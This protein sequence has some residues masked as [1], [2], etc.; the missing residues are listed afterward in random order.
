MNNCQ[1]VEVGI[2]RKIFSDL[3]MTTKK[4]DEREN[5]EKT[6]FNKALLAVRR[7]L[8]NKKKE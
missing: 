2:Y 6:D 3:P 8:S 4:S 7:T 1:V 5:A